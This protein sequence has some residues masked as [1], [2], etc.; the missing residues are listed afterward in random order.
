MI[1]LRNINNFILKHITT[2]FP[3][4]KLSVVLG[5]NGAGKTT[6]L[7]V[8][9]GLVKYEGNVYFDGVCIDEVPP[10]RRGISYV[11]QNN[12]LFKNL[13]VWD[14]IAFGLKV[15]GFGRDFVESQVREMLRLFRIEHLAQRYPATLSGGEAKKVALARALAIRPKA[16]LLDEPFEGLDVEFKHLVEQEIM[17]I[18]KKLKLTTILVTHD[19]TKAFTNANTLHLLWN[20]KLLFS[21]R[22][23]ELSNNHLPLDAKFWLGSIIDVHV[24]DV[25]M[26]EVPYIKLGRASVPLHTLA[27]PTI[28]GKGK[29]KVLIPSNKVRI[30]RRGVV[31]GTV[32]FKER[33][34]NYYRVIV[35]L[36]GIEVPILTPIELSIGSEVN[37]RIGE[38]IIIG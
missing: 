3:S 36:G 34:G 8:I 26:N 22:P 38:A 25:I 28:K 27:N 16:L 15:R 21:G 2:K 35:D 6:L 9:A 20:G 4:G 17:M 29:V 5:P 7:K 30:C 31:R 23:S 14:N 1:E 33:K 19:V 10:N 24:S 13:T 32:I 11:P 37:L 18:I 12:A